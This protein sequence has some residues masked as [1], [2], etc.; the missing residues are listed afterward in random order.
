MYLILYQTTNVRLVQ[1]EASADDKIKLTE[2]VE[3]VSG[4]IKNRCGKKRKCWLP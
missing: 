3:F 2:K 1:I 4:R